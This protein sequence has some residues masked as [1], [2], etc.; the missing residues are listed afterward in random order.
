VEKI[1]TKFFFR[2]VR[3]SIPDDL[4]F[5]KT[6][7]IS[8]QCISGELQEKGGDIFE[9]DSTPVKLHP[10]GDKEWTKAELVGIDDLI[11]NIWDD[12]ADAS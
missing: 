7:E 6:S 2:D 3:V 9:Y 11:T 1:K 5:V 8:S 4:E 12:L 10:Q